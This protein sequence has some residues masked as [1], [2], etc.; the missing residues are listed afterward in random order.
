MPRVSFRLLRGFGLAALFLAAALLGIASGVF[1]AFTGDLPRISALDDYNPGTTTRVLGRDGSVIGEFATERRDLVT[2]DQIPPVLRNAI[3]SAEDGD[4]FNHGGLNLK[5]I[6]VTAV[7]RALFLRRNG[8]ASTLTQQLTRKLFLT[9]EQTLER[10]IKE[11]ILAIQVEKRYTKQEIFAMYC[12]QMYWGHGAYGVEAASELYFA[13]HVSDLTLDEAAMI[14]GIIQGNERESPYRNMPAALYRRNYTLDRMAANGYISAAAASAAK[15]RPII[16]H[17]QPSPPRSIAPYYLEAIR[18]QLEDKYGKEAVWQGG[19]TIKTGLDPV[20][21]QAAARALDAQLRVLDK[22]RGFRKPAHNIIA[23]GKT[24]ETYKNSRWSHPFAVDDVVPAVVLG[25]D[26][27]AIAVAAGKWTGTIDHAGYA[28]TNRKADALVKRGDLIDVQLKKIDAK[29]SSFAASLDQT[30]ELEGAVIAL[31]NH[32]GQIMTMIGGRS[33]EKSQFNRATQALRQVGSLFKPFV[34][35]AAIDSGA[36][37]ED[38]VLHDEPQSFFAGPNQPPYEP[39]NYDRQYE[40]DLPLHWALEDSRNVP[41]VALMEQLDPHKVVP[42]AEKMG[43]TSPLPPYLSTAIGSAEASLIEMTS[44]YTAWPN[45]GVRMSPVLTLDV[46][47]RQGN[48]LET[49]HP[50]PHDVLRADTAYVMT[51]MLHGVVM[52]GTGKAGSASISSD[53]PLGGKTGTTD[54]YTD[55]WFIGFDPDIT[56]GVWVGFD[57]KK[58]IGPDATGAIAAL[59]IWVDIMKAWIAERKAANTDAPSFPKPDNVVVVFGPTGPEA[60]IAGTEPGRGNGPDI[61]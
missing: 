46:I 44:A 34:Y 7:R 43:I 59:P 14:A 56:V 61:H 15:K 10:K 47:D 58:Q 39:K 38:S 55:A 40:G 28:W 36:Y 45:Q 25:V 23:E 30:P 31:D 54:N 2:Y 19:L 42:Y 1:F 24:V 57:T 52:N 11:A 9:D 8:G 18:I 50:E 6:V 26:K 4:F 33:F 13:K 60:F 32:T 37:T 49:S 41:T 27:T 16:T 48:V 12:N 22:A 35:T 51:T 17:G 5:R 53:W 3:I 20:L 29:A 21:Q